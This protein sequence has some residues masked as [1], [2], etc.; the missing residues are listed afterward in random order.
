V[1]SNADF[2]VANAARIRVAAFRQPLVVGFSKLCGQVANGKTLYVHTH[3][4][5]TASPVIPDKNG[6]N[7]L[8]I[9]LS[10]VANFL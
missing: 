1:Q 3:G 6:L 9:A 7:D 5:P 10:V 4:L 2:G 8:G